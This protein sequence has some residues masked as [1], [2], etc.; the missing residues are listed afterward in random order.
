MEEFEWMGMCIFF[1]IDFTVLRTADTK[2]KIEMVSVSLFLSWQN[3][4]T[5]T[6][7]QNTSWRESQVQCVSRNVWLR[8]PGTSVRLPVCLAMVAVCTI[9]NF[10]TGFLFSFW[11]I[12]SLSCFHFQP[13]RLWRKEYYHSTLSDFRHSLS[14]ARITLLGCMVS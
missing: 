10:L 6:W 12:S 2:E 14:S 13:V 11:F 3:R 7:Q 8:H 4:Y 5:A 9:S 1:W